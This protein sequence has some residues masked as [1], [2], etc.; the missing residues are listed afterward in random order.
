MAENISGFETKTFSNRNIVL[1]IG[2][3]LQEINAR[4]SGKVPLGVPGQNMNK[5]AE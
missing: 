4:G 5:A 3:L 2:P 1:I